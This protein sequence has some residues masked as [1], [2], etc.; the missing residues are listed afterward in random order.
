MV[1]KDE[2]VCLYFCV[3]GYRDFDSGCYAEIEVLRGLVDLG[4]GGEWCL[5]G[6]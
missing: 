4:M 5:D 2:V 3:D 1:G 6:K